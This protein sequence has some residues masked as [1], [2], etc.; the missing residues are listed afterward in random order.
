MDRFFHINASSLCC[1]LKSKISVQNYS[2]RNQLRNRAFG[3]SKLVAFDFWIKKWFKRVLELVTGSRPG[4]SCVVS[5]T[6][7]TT[8]INKS[9]EASKITPRHRKFYDFVNQGVLLLAL[10]RY[11]SLDHYT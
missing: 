7:M 2:E 5:H 6:S 9:K 10:C 4:M 1:R 8:Q 3:F 11:R